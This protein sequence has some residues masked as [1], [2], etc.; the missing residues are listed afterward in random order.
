MKIARISFNKILVKVTHLDLQGMI[1]A[2][3]NKT[4][5]L[6][7]AHKLENSAM[8]DLELQT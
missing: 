2:L 3:D 4:R 6:Q 7:G 1:F 8:P 5:R